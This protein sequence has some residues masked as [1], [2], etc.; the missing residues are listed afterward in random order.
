ML[1]AIGFFM[2]TYRLINCIL[3]LS[4]NNAEHIAVLYEMYSFID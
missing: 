3:W 1:K 4:W 2:D